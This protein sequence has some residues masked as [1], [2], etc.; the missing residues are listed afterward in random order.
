MVPSSAD[1][2]SATITELVTELLAVHD[3]RAGKRLDPQALLGDA[4]AATTIVQGRL[5]LTY[6]WTSPLFTEFGYDEGSDFRI[7]SAP[8]HVQG[9]VVVIIHPGTFHAIQK[10]PQ[11]TQQVEQWKKDG[12]KRILM[13]FN[14]TEHPAQI[15]DWRVNLAPLCDIP[16]GLGSLAFNVLTTTNV[17]LKYLDKLSWRYINY[18][19]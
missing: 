18:L 4:F 17:Y 10:T 1:A 8:E 12:R 11:L 15:G 9:D 6:E 3:F 19:H 16:Q 5:T 7:E 13:F 2:P 14:N